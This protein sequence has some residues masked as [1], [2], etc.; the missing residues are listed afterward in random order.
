MST[1]LTIFVNDTDGLREETFDI[2]ARVKCILPKDS[3]IGTILIEDLGRGHSPLPGY[4]KALEIPE[5]GL[6]LDISGGLHL[7]DGHVRHEIE[8]YRCFFRRETP[9]LLA[10]YTKR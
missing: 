7:W 4:I 6:T 9:G 1:P 2:D 3:Y 10:V 8:K 5:D